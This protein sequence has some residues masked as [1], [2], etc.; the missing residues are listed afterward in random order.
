MNAALGNPTEIPPAALEALSIENWM[1]GWKMGGEVS[2]SRV[3]LWG[4]PPHQHVAIESR[5]GVVSFVLLS[6]ES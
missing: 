3:S 2:G 5:W 6:G 4:G 1:D